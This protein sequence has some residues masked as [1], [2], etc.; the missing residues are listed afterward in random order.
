MYIYYFKIIIMKDF[1]NFTNLFELNKSI[2]FEL[3]PVWKTKNFIKEKQIIKLDKDRR[4]KYEKVRKYFNKIHSEFINFSLKNPNFDFNNYLEIYKDFLKNKK[5]NDLLK[6]KNNFEERFYEEI[7]KMFENSVKF[8]LIENNLENIIKEK[9]QDIDFL[10]RKEIFQVLKN[11]YGSEIETCEIINNETWEI[12]SIF[13]GWDWWLLYFEKFFNTRKNFYKIDWTSTAIPTRI[14]KDNLKI[15]IENILILEKIIWKIDF[16]EVQKNFSFEVKKLTE[17]NFFN[18]CFLQNWIDFYN[19][20]IWWETLEN[21]EKLKWINEIINKYRQDNKEKIPFLKKLQKQI[22]SEKS[23]NFIEQ[24]ENI[25]VFFEVLKNF[26]KKSCEKVD[27]LKNIFDKIYYYKDENLEKIFINKIAFNT[28][29]HKFWNSNEFEKIIFEELK[30]DKIEWIKFEKNENKY[31]F[32]DFIALIYFKK[33][34]LN[35]NEENL[36]WKERYYFSEENKD[37]FIDKSDKNLWKQFCEILDFEFKN[38]LNKEIF[39][40]KGKRIEIWFEIYEKNLKEI[41][42]NFDL[43]EKTKI[44]IKDFADTS[45]ILYSFWK[46]F[47]VEKWRNWNLNIDIDND[48]Y[49]WENW[50]IEK[51]Y[52][53]WYDEII[54]PYNLMRNYI[55]KKPWSDN[56]KWK[57]N[58]ENSSLLKWWDINKENY[59]EA[60]ILRDSWK[61]FLWIYNEKNALK[62]IEKIEKNSWEYFEKMIYKYSKD[63]SQNIPKFSTQLKE[64][65]SHFSSSNEDYFVE[66]WSSVWNFIRPLK[67]TKEIFDLNNKVYLKE[68]L[69]I[70]KMR[71]ELKKDEEKKYIKSFQREFL[72]LW[73]NPDIY[74]KSIN[75]WMDF[76]REVLAVYPSFQFFDFSNL[77]ENEKYNFLDEFYADIDK[78]SYNIFFEKISKESI[79]QKLEDKKIF[80]FEIYNKDFENSWK[81][82]NKNLHTIYFENLFSSENILNNFVFK[83]DW[84]A[85][86]FFREWISEEKLWKKIDKKWKEVINAKR[87]NSDKIFFHFPITINRWKWNLSQFLFNQKIN[88]F[89]ADNEEIN[90]L[91]IDRWEKHLAYFSVI[92]Q[93][94]EILESGSFNKIENFDKFWEKI[95]Y[96]ERKIEEIG[97]NLE[98]VETWK[99]VSYMDYKLLLEFKEKKRLLQRQTWKE[100]EQIKDLKKWYISILVRKIADLIIKYNA[101]VIFED[102]NFRFKQIRGWIE[103][104]IYQQLEKALIDKLTFLVNKNEINPEKAWNILKAYQ[105]T[106]PVESLKE[107]W[108]QTGIIFYTEASYTSKIDP[109]TGWRPNLYLKKINA[110][111]NKENILKFDKIIFN[112]EKNRFEFTYDLKNFFAEKANLP[113]NTIWTVCSCV[114]RFKWN[115]FL[116]NNKWGYEHF[117]DL[118]KEFEKLFLSY[119]IDKNLEILSQIKNMSEKWNEKFFENFINLFSLVCQIRNTNENESDDKNDFIL[120]PVE[121]FFD[122]RNSEKF[123]KNLPK[124]GDEN[125]AYNI[126]RKWIIIL[127]KIS[128]NYEKPNLLIRDKDW[129]DFVRKV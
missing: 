55:S 88:K 105:L 14:I 35:Y 126:A 13:D 106:C 7:W 114:E 20:I 58:F 66:K 89:L 112:S 40:E 17:I 100:V 42:K 99:K 123:G 32:P 110:S 5:D 124:N 63:I 91:W 64:V 6:L 84:N 8:F 93:K 92:N 98:L 72:N 62:N 96:S 1:K 127:E 22:L 53:T 33:A 79:Y 31:K 67:I 50:Y 102:L 54:K 78:K 30:K 48:F 69:E 74:R 70:S 15:F 10:Y 90:I 25:E 52:E 109:I 104:S 119:N 111:K 81:N 23:W 56:K 117:S 24:I 61:Y 57:I 85:E 11:K 87:Y 29:T 21:G 108:K 47:S 82:S 37:W 51:F 116:N 125:W 12:D 97:W 113:K 49:N 38:I 18:K 120:S 118:T 27:F 39:D 76:C 43:N 75:K 94:W 65:I 129:D 73:W 16:S 60:F 83:L 46:Y 9:E 71:Q 19:K 121:P 80:L 4:K 128:E 44:L 103:K 122:S 36:F 86:I 2:K 3:K 68:N 28:I 26:H 77:K 59:Y 107:V 41:L 34:F 95:F 45:L 115:K 101:I